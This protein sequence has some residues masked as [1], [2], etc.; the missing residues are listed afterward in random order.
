MNYKAQ[1]S[2]HIIFIFKKVKSGKNYYFVSCLLLM[3]IFVCLLYIHANMREREN[4]RV[5]ACCENYLSFRSHR[6]RLQEK[7]VIWMFLQLQFNSTVHMFK[8]QIFIAQ[9]FNT[10]LQH[11]CSMYRMNNAHLLNSNTVFW[12]FSI[13]YLDHSIRPTLRMGLLIFS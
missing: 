9:Q 13:P 2:D 12:I 3:F 5:Y 10:F 7:P 4:M 6:L 11:L 1:L 8:K